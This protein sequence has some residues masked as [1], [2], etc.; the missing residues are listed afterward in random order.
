MDFFVR[1]FAR[2]TPDQARSDSRGCVTLDPRLRKDDSGAWCIPGPL[3]FFGR[4]DIRVRNSKF[5]F[6]VQRES[7]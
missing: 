5:L 3:S 1:A 4:F 2:W 6:G 7:E